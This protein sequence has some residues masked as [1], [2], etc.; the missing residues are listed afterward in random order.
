MSTVMR[1]HRSCADTWPSPREP[2]HTYRSTDTPRS[3][4]SN[5]SPRNSRFSVC[6]STPRNDSTAHSKESRQAHPR[7]SPPQTPHDGIR[8][9]FPRSPRRVP[10][11]GSARDP[12]RCAEANPLSRSA[13]FLIAGPARVLLIWRKGAPGVWSQVGRST[14]SGRWMLSVGTSRYTASRSPGSAGRQWCSS[15]G[16]LTGEDLEYR[17][18]RPPRRR[19]PRHLAVR[20]ST[21]RRTPRDVFPMRLDSENTWSSCALERYSGAGGPVGRRIRRRPFWRLGAST[22]V[23]QGDGAHAWW[24]ATRSP[25]S[26]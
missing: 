23:A 16:A 5:G 21:A 8:L 19:W 9:G 12:E 26:P 20:R 2:G 25:A 22:L 14:R 10:G 4:N 3:K 6:A 18:R 7:N 15:S 1:V 24:G 17:G 13:S 11:C